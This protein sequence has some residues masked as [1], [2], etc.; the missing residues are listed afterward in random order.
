MLLRHELFMR[1]APADDATL[2]SIVDDAFLPLVVPG[3]GA[4]G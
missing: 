1:L 4:A 2:V 3:P